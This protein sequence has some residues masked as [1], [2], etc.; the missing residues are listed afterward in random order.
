ML[1]VV[2]ASLLRI[3][4]GP[5]C[6]VTIVT[7]TNTTRLI[8]DQ[9]PNSNSRKRLAQKPKLDPERSLWP[10]LFFFKE[11]NALKR[12][13]KLEKTASSKKRTKEG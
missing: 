2:Q 12:Q 5:T 11:I 13:L 3:I 4:R 8:A 1:P 6:G 10:S 9:L 7:R